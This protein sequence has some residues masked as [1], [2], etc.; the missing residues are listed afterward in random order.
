MNVVANSHCSSRAASRR[1]FS[2]AGP[3]KPGHLLYRGSSLSASRRI[4][5]RIASVARNARSLWET[6]LEKGEIIYMENRLLLSD[7]VSPTHPFLNGGG[8]PT[9]VR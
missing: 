2:T 7:S 5:T 1:S 9:G 3:A 8:D 4:G 6:F